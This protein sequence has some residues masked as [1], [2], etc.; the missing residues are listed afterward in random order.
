LT[1]LRLLGSE[2]LI[3]IPLAVEQYTIYY[4]SNI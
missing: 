1:N 2:G 3:I 4:L